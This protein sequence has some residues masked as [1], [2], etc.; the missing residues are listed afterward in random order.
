MPYLFRPKK[1]AKK[2]ADFYRMN[3]EDLENEAQLEYGTEYGDLDN[4]SK[5]EIALKLAKLRGYN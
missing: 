3:Y 1:T 5:D 4:K 2:E